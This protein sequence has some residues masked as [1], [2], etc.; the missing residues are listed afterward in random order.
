MNDDVRAAVMEYA[1]ELANGADVPFCGSKVKAAKVKAAPAVPTRESR[2]RAS[3]TAAADKL[4]DD[5]LKKPLPKV[6][7][8][9]KSRSR[10]GALQET[11]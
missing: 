7:P 2:S 4:K 1:E 11:N 9:R 8:E 3:K 6:T 5:D 10:R